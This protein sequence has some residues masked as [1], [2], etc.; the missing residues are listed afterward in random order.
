MNHDLAFVHRFVAS[1]NVAQT[2]TFLLLHGTGG[3]EN[4]LLDLGAQLWPQANLLSPRGRVLE[5]QRPRFFR[6][7]E[8]GVFD[9]DD[10]KLQTHALSDFISQAAIHY[11]FD[12]RNVVAL[13]F[14]NGANIAASL[15]LLHPET[16]RAAILLRA[17]VP[18]EGAPHRD[19]AN[20]PV[21]L[22]SGENDP[23]VPTENANRLAQMLGQR[24]A[25]VS[26]LWQKAGH[27]LTNSD[28]EA[29]KNWLQ[30]LKYSG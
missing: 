21:L 27:N 23:I 11:G 22:S 14:S 29:A 1:T 20:V 28:L 18:L 24:G 15:L 7:L 30:N 3:N 8:E 12:A 6:R 26:H 17:M 4:D 10:L 16:L 13:G 5:N 19:L 25:A 9:T 2:P